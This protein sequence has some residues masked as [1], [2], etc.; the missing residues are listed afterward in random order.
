[1]L[2]MWL[3]FG[4]L[5]LYVLFKL[6]LLSCVAI[7]DCLRACFVPLVGVWLLIVL[8][9]MRLLMVSLRLVRVSL[10]V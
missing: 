1:M 10:V 7:G 9:I 5:W 6:V 3:R 4:A 2:V 8:G